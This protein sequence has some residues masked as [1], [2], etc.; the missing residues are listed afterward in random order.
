MR[1]ITLNVNGIRAAARKG[2]FTW[3]AGQNADLVCLQEIKAQLPQLQDPV[4]WPEGFHCHYYPARNKK[5]YGGVALYARKEPDEVIYGFGWPEMDVEGRYLE[6]RFG[7]LSVASVYVP[8]GTSGE[9]RQ[10]FKF[11]F[12]ERFLEFLRQCARSGRDYIFCGDFNIAH[13]KI[14]IKNWRANQ[15][16]SGFLPEE[17][18]WM[19]RVLEQEGW[20][21]AFRVLNQEPDQYTW[22]SNRGRAWEKNVGWRI[23]YQI[24]SPSLKDRIRRVEIYKE[25]RFS[26]HAPL[27]IDYDYPF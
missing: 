24:V 13:K 20:V 5:G 27:I 4:F 15:N 12:L 10:A 14:D 7:R 3:L 23:D 21:D 19:D 18:A 26:D 17:R 8:S 25:Q 11:R 9:A 22:W 16:R 6:G 2:F 1:V